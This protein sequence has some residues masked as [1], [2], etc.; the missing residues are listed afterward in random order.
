VPVDNKIRVALLK[1]II[2][3]TVDLKASETIEDI[4]ERKEGSCSLEV[5]SLMT[6]VLLIRT[7]KSST[8]YTHTAKYP[9]VYYWHV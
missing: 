1:L 3:N 6:T 4:E 5:H 8:H 7:S 9:H 2:I